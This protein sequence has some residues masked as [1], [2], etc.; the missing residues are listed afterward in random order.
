MEP[1]I[2]AWGELKQSILQLTGLSRDVLHVYAGLALTAI[3]GLVSRTGPANWR[4]LL[5]PALL[6]LAGEALD[7]LYYMGTQT[8]AADWIA[9]SAKDALNTLL[10]PAIMILV[11]K[12]SAARNRK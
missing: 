5:L 9:E 10:A 4:L 8:D 1:G 12:G 2:A 7:V 6:M 11:A 3:A